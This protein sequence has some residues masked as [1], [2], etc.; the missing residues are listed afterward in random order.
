MRRGDAAARRQSGFTYVAV[1]TA[2]AIFGIGLAA[3]GTS[4]SAL[5]RRDKEDELLE[6]G[7]AY[8]KAIGDYY[9]RTPGNPK[10]Y[11]A[12]LEELVEDRRF[13]GTARHLRKVYGDPVNHGKEWG[14]I[15][16]GDGG[17]AG[18]YSLS[19]AETLR[20][21]PVKLALLTVS[22]DRYSDWKFVYL[23]AP[24]P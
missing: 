20:R 10:R 18:V 5:A 4:W 1:L 15:R 8:Q 12:A 22:G 13:V 6:I 2:L 11:P 3:L 7:A 19:E 21:R 16:A 24:S 9:Q 17:I 14:V 23:P